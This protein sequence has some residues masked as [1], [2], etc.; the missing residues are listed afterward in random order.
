M[1]GRGDDDGDF[2]WMYG[3]GP[4]GGSGD[5]E[6]TRR[7]PVQPRPGV[8]PPRSP[9]RLPPAQQYGAQPEP[10]S[11]PP[12]PAWSARPSRWRRPRTWFR[13][14]ILLLATWLAF[15]VAVPLF[16]WSKVDKV[17]YEPSG[18]RPSEQP[19]TTY[20]LVGSDSRAGLTKEERRKLHTGNETSELT[21]TIMLLHTGDGPTTLI[22]IPRDSPLEIPGHGVSKINSAFSKGGT[23]LLVQTLEK[24]TGVRIDGYVEIGFG[25][26]VGVVDAVGGIEVCPKKRI[27]DK[28]SGLNIKKGCQSVDGATA[29]AYARARK[30]SP[31]S[32]LARVQQQREVVA[33]VGKKV[34]SPWSVINPV[35]YWKL[36]GAVPDFFRFGEGMGPYAAS[37]WALAMTDAPK[38]CT[39]PLA[40]ADATWDRKRAA[41]LFDT[42]AED[43]TDDITAQLCTATGLAQ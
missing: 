17:A 36:N 25:G 11:S 31:I 41:K 33:A 20:L 10:S 18:D 38:S 15:L 26:L 43:R 24:A 8:S 5:P 35:R 7:I 16:T 22:S 39:V 2:D 1:A 27:R 21:D 23:P 9:D 30:Y 40:S 6:P 37:Q 3:S 34:L 19:G 13:L 14:V 32:D 12:P 42:I 4:Q 28:P 29:L